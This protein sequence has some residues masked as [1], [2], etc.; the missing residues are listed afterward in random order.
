MPQESY[1]KTVSGIHFEFATTLS[2][3]TKVILDVVQETKTFT[4]R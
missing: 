4:L 2:I 3:Q 1:W